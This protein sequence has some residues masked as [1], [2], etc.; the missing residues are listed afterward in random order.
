LCYGGEAKNNKALTLAAVV[1]AGQLVVT[2]CQKSTT[3]G[4]GG[5]SLTIT[6]PSD[7]TI[8]AGDKKD[9]KI[10]ITRKGFNDPVEVK[11]ENLPKGV[12]LVDEGKKIGADESSGTFRFNASPDAKQDEQLVTVTATGG[13]LTATEKFKMKVEAQK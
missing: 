3:E 13:G 2:G 5:K 12:T 7:V 8:K 6:Q 1:S 11:F 4:P 9:V 10:S